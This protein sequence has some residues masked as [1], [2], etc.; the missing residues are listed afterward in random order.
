MTTQNDD[1]LTPQMSVQA[2]GEAQINAVGRISHVKNLH[3]GNRYQNR[4]QLPPPVVEHINPIP[5]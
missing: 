1:P 3:V 5:R 4:C 2:E